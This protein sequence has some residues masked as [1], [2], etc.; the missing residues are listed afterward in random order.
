MSCAEGEEGRVYRD[1]A[2]VA[3]LFDER[4]EAVTRTIAQVIGAAHAAG[5]KS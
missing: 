4:N 2:L 5:R 1:S 3:H